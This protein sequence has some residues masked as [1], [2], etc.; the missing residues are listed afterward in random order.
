M[1]FRHGIRMLGLGLLGL[2]V[3]ASCAPSGEAPTEEP[4]AAAT[5]AA[6][7][8]LPVS[9]NDVMVTMV[10]QAADPLWVAAWHNPSTDAEWRE[11]ERRAYQLQIAGSLLTVPGTGPVDDEWVS[12]PSWPK[13]T[14]QLRDTAAEAVLAVQRR[15]LQAISSAGDR[16]V[17]VCEGCH[18]DFKFALPTGGKFGELSPNEADLEGEKEEGQR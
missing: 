1:S 13:W 10:N 3:L 18:I 4:A 5:P 8:R 11:L 12:Q 7:T 17:D 9:L 15:D 14:S 2:A 6:V 16:L